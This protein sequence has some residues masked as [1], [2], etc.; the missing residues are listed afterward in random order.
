MSIELP[1]MVSLTITDTIFGIGILFC[2]NDLA[3]CRRSF[4]VVSGDCV[5]NQC[6]CYHNDLKFL[7]RQVWANSADPDQNPPKGAG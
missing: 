2:T 6:L 3:R 4:V 1:E 7:D 5:R